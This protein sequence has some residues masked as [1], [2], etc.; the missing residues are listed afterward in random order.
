MDYRQ[1]PFIWSKIIDKFSLVI[2]RLRFRLYDI[3]YGEKMR[4]T[5]F[6]YL[7]LENTSI[8]KVGDYFEFS[9]GHGANAL[10]RN[11]RGCIK[12]ERNSKIIIGDNVGISSGVVWAKSSIRI[13]DNVKIGA[14]SIILDTDCHSLDWKIRSSM[15]FTSLTES[16]DSCNAKSSPIVIEDDVM[17]GMGCVI[18]KGVKIGEHSIIAAG[19]I[20]TRNIPSDVIAG[21]NPCKVIKHL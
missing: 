19:S 7:I 17:I 3:E 20:V 6:P 10:A 8:V 21:G 18:L 12:A 1:I 15:E 9:N 13:G 16:L 5:G 14:G 11:I 2:N 4:V